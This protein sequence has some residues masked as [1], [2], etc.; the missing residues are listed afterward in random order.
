MLYKHNLELE[1]IKLKSGP[2]PV[3]PNDVRTRPWSQ[4]DITKML[5]SPDADDNLTDS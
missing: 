3:D 5:N 4:E 2:E 1:K